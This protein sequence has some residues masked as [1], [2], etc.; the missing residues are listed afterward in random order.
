VYSRLKLCSTLINVDKQPLKIK[1]KY[2]T[3]LFLFSESLK[4]GFLLPKKG[5]S[6]SRLVISKKAI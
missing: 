6:T 2:K 3:L 5:V 4:V 1:I